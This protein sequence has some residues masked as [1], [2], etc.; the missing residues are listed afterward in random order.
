M[1]RLGPEELHSLRD[2]I[3]VTMVE[4]DGTTNPDIAD[5]LKSRLTG[6]LK[7]YHV[8]REEEWHHDYHYWGRRFGKN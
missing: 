3:Y 5:S 1:R 6:L 2:K 7:N 8:A 4:L